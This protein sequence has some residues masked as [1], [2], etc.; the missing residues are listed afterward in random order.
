MV[1]E[2]LPRD[3]GVR[4]VHFLSRWAAVAEWWPS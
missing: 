2:D 4:G 1:V 3:L